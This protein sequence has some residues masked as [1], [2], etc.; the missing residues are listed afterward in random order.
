MRRVF[1]WWVDAVRFA[2]RRAT[3]DK[4][5]YRVR[6]IEAGSWRAWYVGPV[7]DGAA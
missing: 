7:K 4:Q 2:H 1:F 3:I 6:M 5:R